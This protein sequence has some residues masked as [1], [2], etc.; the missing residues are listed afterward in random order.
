M[1]LA[2]HPLSPE[3]IAV[4]VAYK[5]PMG[6]ADR[7]LPRVPVGLQTFKYNTWPLAETLAIPN[8]AVGR[9]SMPNQVDLYA[10]ET[11]AST[12]DHGLDDYIPQADID[13]ANGKY[14]PKARA[15]V[16]IE[17]Y[18]QINREK[19]VA[20]LVFTAANYPAANKVTLSGTSQWSDAA[21]TPIANIMTGIDACLMRPNVMVIGRA[22]YTKLAQHADILKAVNRSSGDKGVAARQAIAD[23]FELEEV[24][25]GEGQM[26]TAVKGQTAVIARIWGKHALLFYRNL[27][28][29][30]QGGLTFGLTAEFGGKIAW[31]AFDPKIGLK[32]AVQVR[33]GESV[34]ELIVANQAAYFIENAVA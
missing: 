14:D 13:N 10:T 8:D 2:P 21:S 3:L 4:A 22:A 29:D 33:N 28:A 11:T 1:A 6:I 7:V 18:I 15:V 9:K 32:G 34:K 30:T 12:E 31:E 16:Q 19:R 23:M 17:D 5:N 26:N 20:D 27:V 24:L 25:V